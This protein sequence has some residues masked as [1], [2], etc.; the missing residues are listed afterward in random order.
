MGWGSPTTLLTLDLA[1]IIE[2]PAP[3]R[4]ILL[5][6]LSATLPDERNA[7]LVLRANFLGT[8]DFGAK[9]IS[10]DASLVGS[11]ILQ[12]TLTGDAAFRLYQGANPVFLLTSGGFH[13]AFRPPANADLPTLRRLSLALAQG[14]DFSLTLSTYIAVT[15]NTVQFGSRLD[16][17]VRLPASFS[18]IGFLSFDALFQFNPFRIQVQ[19]AAGVAIKKGNSTK[20]TLNLNLA[21]S[22]PA[23]WHANGEG[24][25]KILFI[26]I[27]FR[28]E[29]TFGGGAAPQP[30]PDTNVR[31]LLQQALEDRSNW[32]VEQPV[33]RASNTVVLRAQEVANQLLVDPSGALVV[34]QK[35]APLG[36]PMERFGDARPVNGN[37]FDITRAFIGVTGADP[38]DLS[39]SELQEVKDSFSPGQFRRMSNAEKLSAPS[40]QQM[41]N[42]VRLA[43]L[44]GYAGGPASAKAVAYEQIILRDLTGSA[45]STPPPPAPSAPVVVPAQQ[46]QQ[47]TKNSAVGR[48]ARSFERRR[49]SRKA[50]DQIFWDED[51]YLIVSTRDLSPLEGTAS[52]PNE[53]QATAHLNQ[54]LQSDPSWAGELQVVPAYQLNV[55]AI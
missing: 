36:Y 13:P 47:L 38:I 41:R 51:D 48:S 39:G 15:S 6:V 12:F 19:V 22:G 28:V 16:L 24:S 45:G 18:L 1:L 8:V 31:P 49:P 23:P 26:K 34:R 50:P 37:R 3:V 40:F 46:Y 29:R 33:N 11:R 10:F 54:L 42:G 17:F 53:A 4:L 55:P 32:E 52:F 5:G 2:L 25:F 21:L 30:L 9:R 35:V 7:I 44:A 43:G 27:K 20:L 14:G